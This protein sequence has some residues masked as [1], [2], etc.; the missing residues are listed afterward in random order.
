[1]TRKGAPKGAPAAAAQSNHGENTPPGRE[2][3]E[4]CL[5]CGH[6]VGHASWC[7][8]DYLSLERVPVAGD[9]GVPEHVLERP[10]IGAVSAGADLEAARQWKP[11]GSPS[12]LAD[13]DREWVHDRIHALAAAREVRADVHR[14]RIRSTASWL[15]H[16][17]HHHK[18]T[19]ADADARIDR[20]LKAFDPESSVAILLVPFKEARQI[21]SDA[22]TSTFEGQ[23]H[24]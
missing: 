16:Q 11:S 7:G 12:P 3:R 2:Q 19:L 6:T 8:P 14:E 1:V 10:T 15:G 18:V 20:M 21:A 24:E 4:P 13:D 17:V 9:A 23:A 22:F 5:A